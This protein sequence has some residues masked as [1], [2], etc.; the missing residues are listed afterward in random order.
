LA[1]I[2]LVHGIAQ[3]QSGEAQLEEEWLPAVA[4]GLRAADRPDLAK[5]IW[6]VTDH[7]D[8]ITAAMAF[9]GDLFVV[10][11]SMGPGDAAPSPGEQA[12][13]A[14]DLAQEWL[15]R[16]A[17]RE[18]SDQH[19]AV[20]QL[21]YLEAG[22]YEAQGPLQE[23]Q[24]SAING[25]TKLRWFAPFGMAFAGQFVNRALTQVTAYLTDDSIRSAVQGRVARLVD[26]DTKVIIGH[27]LGSVVAL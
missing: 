5:R 18:V 2:V 3:E 6:P 8:R 7:P 15:G 25:L 17:N 20:T 11:G 13:I 19:A 22:A 23:A 24:R 14:E 12:E 10:P 16:A 27:S 9:F 26:P 21:S 4:D 1:E